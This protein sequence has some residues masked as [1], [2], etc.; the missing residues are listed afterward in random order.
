MYEGHLDGK[1]S[2]GHYDLYDI[3]REIAER[4]IHLHI[5]PSRETDLYEKLGEE[6]TFIHY[7]GRMSPPHLMTEL[8]K[9][10]FG[11][12]GFNIKKNT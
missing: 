12:S 5:Y 3:F 8:T 11:W 9:Y 2:G 6:D 7:H 4:A 1:R 10:D